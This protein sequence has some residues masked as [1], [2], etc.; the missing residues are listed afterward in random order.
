MAGE[1]AKRADVEGQGRG[2]EEGTNDEGGYKR[3]GIICGK[4]IE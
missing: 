3:D 2:A 1:M 4:E